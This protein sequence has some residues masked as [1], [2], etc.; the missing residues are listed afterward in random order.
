MSTLV[1]VA[2]AP[3]LIFTFGAEMPALGLVFVGAV[4]FAF[5]RVWTSSPPDIP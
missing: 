2:W 1:G 4:G 3:A 5:F